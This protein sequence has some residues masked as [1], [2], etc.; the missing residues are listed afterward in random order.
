MRRN[1]EPSYICST[2]TET[3]GE[4]GATS[5]DILLLILTLDLILTG[6]VLLYVGSNLSPLELITAPDNCAAANS[7]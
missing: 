5:L 1:S 7:L 3:F 2:K 6:F 4:A